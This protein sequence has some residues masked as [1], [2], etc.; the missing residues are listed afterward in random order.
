MKITIT[1]RLIAACLLVIAHGTANAYEEEKEKETC[2]KP[3]FSDF[4]LP[5]YSAANPVE[6]AAESEFSFKISPYSNLETLSLSAKKNQLTFKVDSNSSF[7]KIT[8]KLPAEFNG[9]FVRINARVTA[10]LGCYDAAGWL[11]KVANQ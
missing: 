5:I 1:L 7:H 10:V 8:A 9:Q 6:A 3:R 11:I 4:T 2:Q